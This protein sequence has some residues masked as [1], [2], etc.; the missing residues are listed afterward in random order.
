MPKILGKVFLT[1]K[2]LLGHGDVDH[3]PHWKKN[4]EIRIKKLVESY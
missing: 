4:S 1:E 3:G 2:L